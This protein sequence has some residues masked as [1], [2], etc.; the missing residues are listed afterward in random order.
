VP[1][2]PLPEIALVDSDNGV[3]LRSHARAAA[4]AAIHPLHAEA[5]GATLAWRWKIDRVVSAADMEMRSGDDFAARVYV[6]FDVPLE[7]LPFAERWKVRLARLLHGDRL[8][9]AAICYVWDNRHAPGSTRWSPY[10]DRV[11]MVVLESGTA[12]TGTWVDERRDM[13]A[14]FRAAFGGEWRGR[15]PAISGVA[16]G[17]DTDQTGEEATAWFSDL[18]LEHIR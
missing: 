11:R 5:E 8:P 12:S 3:V 6:F 9:T 16:A 18:R 7:S 4:G 15:L 2:V 10:S 13:A 1:R 14:D 17:N